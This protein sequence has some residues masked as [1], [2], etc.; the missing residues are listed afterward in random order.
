[1]NISSAPPWSKE[2]LNEER[3]RRLRQVLS[4]S[5]A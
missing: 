4:L 3:T 1:M 2:P 5:L